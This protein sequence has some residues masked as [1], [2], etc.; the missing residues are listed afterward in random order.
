MTLSILSSSRL[1][2]IF[3]QFNRLNQ[4][5]LSIDRKIED[6]TSKAKNSKN[7]FCEQILK[8]EKKKKREKDLSVTN[9]TGLDIAKYF[10]PLQS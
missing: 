1:T 9:F 3:K 7:P 5:R 2:A 8:K 6:K 10:L 4:S